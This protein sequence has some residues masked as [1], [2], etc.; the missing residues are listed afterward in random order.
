MFDFFPYFFT[1]EKLTVGLIIKGSHRGAS[2]KYA[3]YSHTLMAR[4][5]FRPWKFIQDTGSSSH[6]G[7]IMA[8]GQEA[9]GDSLGKSFRSSTQNCYV[10]FIH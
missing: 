1:N 5:S 9:N 3:Q 8:R 4:T 10:E 2:N 7:L 6:C